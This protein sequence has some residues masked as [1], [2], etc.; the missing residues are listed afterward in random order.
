MTLEE[1]Q[2]AAGP[3]AFIP[4]HPGAPFEALEVVMARAVKP[5]RKYLLWID[6]VWGDWR[7][8]LVMEKGKTAEPLTLRFWDFSALPALGSG[9]GKLLWQCPAGASASF[10]GSNL[11]LAGAG[12]AV[13]TQV[14]GNDILLPVKSDTV[15]LA[16]DEGVRCGV[17]SGSLAPAESAKWIALLTPHV[18]YRWDAGFPGVVKAARLLSDDAGD[19]SDVEA[20]FDFHCFD[21]SRTVSRIA[22]EAA[23]VGSSR[24]LSCISDTTGRNLHL[25]PS[26]GAA[27]YFETDRELT[28]HASLWGKF[29]IDTSGAVAP[30]A[31]GTQT[32]E[33]MPGSAGTEFFQLFEAG[34]D[35][36]QFF[37]GQSAFVEFG[38]E[39][40]PPK[41][42]DRSTTAWIAPCRTGEEAAWARSGFGYVAQPQEHPLYGRRNIA[43]LGVGLLDTPSTVL[44]DPAPRR[45]DVCM[46][47]FPFRGVRDGELDQTRQLDINALAHERATIAARSVAAQGPALGALEDAPP[48]TSTITTP[49]GLLID[50]DAQNQ[51]K[52][53]TLG[54]AAGDWS[55]SIPRPD[56]VKRWALQESLS[57][58]DPF[59]VIG[60]Q[61]PP[62]LPGPAEPVVGTIELSLAIAGWPLKLKVADAVAAPLPLPPAPSPAPTPGQRPA[63][64]P[65]LP[66]AGS[67]PVLVIK[68]AKGSLKDMLQ[69]AGLW[70]MA[71]VFN[72]DPAR[73]STEAVA[74]LY[75]LEQLKNGLSPL[76]VPADQ[77]PISQELVPYYK[78]L[79]AKVTDPE[80]TGALIFNG[81]T[82]LNGIPGHVAVLTQGEN[83]PDSFNVPVLGVDI[84]RVVPSGSQMKLER[85][86]A[87]G[88]IHYHS[89]QPLDPKAA[90]F[91]FKVRGVNAVFDNTEL[92]T[93]LATMQLRVGEYFGEK[94]KLEQ[95]GGKSRILDI[96]GRYEA[97]TAGDGQYIFR[98]LGS[99]S[100]DFGG[101]GL[102]SSLTVTRIDVTS[103]RLGDGTIESRFAMWGELAFGNRFSG[104]TGI[105]KI[106]FENAALILRGAQFGADAGDVRVAFDRT[107]ASDPHGL[108]ANFPFQLSG[109]RWA[110]K[111]QTLEGAGF[112]G[113]Q[114]P[115]ISGFEGSNFEFGLELDLNLGSMGKLFEAAQFLKARVLLG[116]HLWEENGTIRRE[117]SIGFRFVGGN[118]PLDI[119]ING[120]LRLTAEQVLLKTYDH[121]PGIGLGLYKPQLDV[122][123][124]KVPSNPRDTL[125]AFLPS[126]KDSIAW[127][128]ARPS[129]TVGPLELDYFAM[130]QRV[131]LVPSGA[132]GPGAT[133]QSVIDASCKQMNPSV[134]SSGVATFPDIGSLY[135]PEAGWG[136]V[137]RG[138]VSS[139]A[140]RFVFMD[141]IDR[142]GLGVDIP[143]IAK[144][145]VLYRKLSDGLG[146]F[147]AEIEPLYRSFEFGTANVTLPIV[148]F[149]ALTN[150]GWS[151]NIGY[152]GNDFS[153]GT[154]VQVLPFI[155]SGGV[156]FGRLD[157]R[158]SYVLNSPD[159]TRSELIRQLDLNPVI[160]MSFAARV[161]IGKEFREGVFTAGITLSVYGIF[162]GAIGTPQDPRFASTGRPRRYLKIYGAAGILL[163]IF[164]SVNFAIVSAAVS[165]RVWVETGIRFETWAPVL[166][167]A[168]A[169]VSVYVHFVI[170]RFSVFG[171]TIEIAIDFS[172]STRVR[173]TQ[174]IADSFDGSLP[175]VYKPY[176]GLSMEPM[177]LHPFAEHAALAP[178]R[179]DPHTVAATPA[180]QSCAVTLEPMIADSKPVLLPLLVASGS[181]SP[182]IATFGIHLF[183][184]ALRLSLGLAPADPLPARVQVDALRALAL[185]L[186]PPKGVPLSRWGEVPLDFAQLQKFMESHLR[187]E[188][189][190][191]ADLRAEQGRQHVTGTL[192]PW[193]ADLAILGSVDTAGGKPIRDFRG[194]DATLVDDS[195]EKSLYDDLA[196]S[197]PLYR[198]VEAPQQVKMAL[199]DAGQVAF[200][201]GSK[202]SLDVVA[203]D[204]AA[205]L[206]QGVAH[207]AIQA[208]EVLLGKDPHASDIA[209]Q[210]LL[211][212]L[213]LPDHDGTPAVQV[214]QHASSFLHHGLRVP[215]SDRSAGSL[216]LS[217][218]LRTELGLEGLAAQGRNW[219]LTVRPVTGFAGPWIDGICDI[220]AF[221]AGAALSRM[222]ELQAKLAT[223]KIRI[224]AR[225][226]D[227]L[228]ATTRPRRFT[229]S[230]GVASAPPSS[231]VST[232][233][234]LRLPR[235]LL[236]LLQRNGPQVVATSTD[237]PQD[238]D[239]PAPCPLRSFARIELRLGLPRV[240]GGNSYPVLNADQR[241]REL[242]K[243][244]TN[245]VALRRAWLAFGD[246]KLQPTV[247]L[248]LLADDDVLMFV[249]NFSREPAPEIQMLQ[250]LSEPEIPASSTL[251]TPDKLAQVLWMAS[252][253]NAPGFELAFRKGN[254]IAHLFK[255]ATV[256][257]ADILFELSTADILHPV[258]D[259]LMADEADAKR[260]VIIETTKIRELV[261]GT[262]DGQ[263]AIEL[264][265]KNPFFNA[266][267]TP[268]V[269]DFA[270]FRAR[271]ELADYEMKDGSL[272]RAKVVPVRVWLDDAEREAARAAEPEWWT[273]RLLVPLSRIADASP[274][275]SIGKDLKDLIVPGLRDGA[276]HYLDEP[277]IDFAWVG[278]NTKVLYRDAIP[279]LE[280]IPG[281]TAAWQLE[282]AAAGPRAVV[283]LLWSSSQ[284][285]SDLKKNDARRIALRGQFER[286]AAMF[287]A[288]GFTAHAD[289]GF[290]GH[291]VA[292]EDIRQRLLDWLRAVVKELEDASD[293]D[294]TC[295]PIVIV[296]PAA[297]LPATTQTPYAM[298]VGITLE[299]EEALCDKRTGN[300]DIWFARSCVAPGGL[301]SAANWLDW[302][303]QVRT[304]FDET[305]T[306]VRLQR[307]RA[308]SVGDRAE[309]PVPYLMRSS[310]LV[311]GSAHATQAVF[312]AP[313]PLAKTL[314]SGSAEVPLPNGQTEQY[315]VTDMDM[316][317]VASR[318]ADAIEALLDPRAAA[319]LCLDAPAQYARLAHAKRSIAELMA[320]RLASVLDKGAAASNEVREKFR[321]AARADVRAA[322]AP[323]AAVEVQL[324]PATISDPKTFLWGHID[325]GDPKVPSADGLAFS[326]VR[327]PLGQAGIEG[328][329]D[330]VARWAAPGTEPV[331]ALRGRMSMQ[332]I[333]VEVQGGKEIDGY[334]PSDWYEVLWTDEMKGADFI[335]SSPTGQEWTIPLPLR[336][337]PPTPSI[338]R[339]GFDSTGTASAR[340]LQDYVRRARAW[341]YVISLMVPATS[342]DTTEVAVR[343]DDSPSLR[344]LA[345]DLLFSALAAFAR[346]E[347]LVAQVTAQLIAGTSPDPKDVQL[348]VSL[349]ESIATALAS[350]PVVPAL[351]DFASQTRTAVLAKS[352]N[353]AET[354]LRWTVT[355]PE[356]QTS[357]SA[358][359]LLLT[360]ENASEASEPIAADALDPQAGI[361]TY[362]HRPVVDTTLAGV[363]GLSPRQVRMSALDVMVHGNAMPRVMSR[364]NAELAGAGVM[365]SP[366]FI[367]ETPAVQTPDPLIPHLVHTEQYDM[368]GGAAA[369]PLAAWLSE[370]RTALAS[371]AN[372]DTFTLDI[373]ARFQLPLASSGGTTINYYAPLPSLKEVKPADGDW[374]LVLAGYLQPALE[375]VEPA[376]RQHG[377]LQLKVKIFH[378]A[379]HGAKRPALSLDELELPLAKVTLKP[380]LPT[381][382]PAGA[383]A[384]T[385][386]WTPWPI[387]SF[388]FERMRGLTGDAEQLELARLAWAHFAI[389]A[390]EPMIATSTPPRVADLETRSDAVEWALCNKAAANAVSSAAGVT[391]AL[392]ECAPSPQEA[393][394]PM[395]AFAGEV[396]KIAGPLRRRG[397]ERHLFLWG[398]PS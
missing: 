226:E 92:R 394:W 123:G 203:E 367:F 373:T 331:A 314:R 236:A 250:A 244:M 116:W 385:F 310:M 44:F 95:P 346:H 194:A 40:K 252:T 64:P 77:K 28:A 35:G 388:V 187:L 3:F 237:D 73:V 359:L 340:D 231:T 246:A 247:P 224:E 173:I 58:P 273:H 322:F 299:R 206:V 16:L 336:L 212:A 264:R 146:I 148:N 297:S 333:Y 235:P 343:F 15:R 392:L 300:S 362:R 384:L 279:Q 74:A 308:S 360:P 220:D 147:S 93:F 350:T 80:W 335:I 210:N 261:S 241:I 6:P 161:G 282:R 358:S 353:A 249:S 309:V 60:A 48:P 366:A 55:L 204:W 85:T 151:I 170:A 230:D 216:P 155:G 316:N 245:G 21:A 202:N 36:L 339:H 345:T 185:R 183:T 377:T 56:G 115:G 169:G 128:W 361:A 118:G 342:H 368:S 215:P 108:L 328:S 296:I 100:F 132:F 319:P 251:A 332:P 145:D 130:G 321:D 260:I 150:G 10:A 94:S 222:N 172:F 356:F 96:I 79:Y 351:I 20:Q 84:N 195:W 348:S 17:V 313:T 184:W 209:L 37:P 272:A 281:V 233:R 295:A 54:E 276:G 117:F 255:D 369:K 221:D 47:F 122:M 227:D 376:S 301:Q 375:R 262:P 39:T 120:V 307:S 395:S 284:L 196:Q 286:W 382:K 265:R 192:L 138:K 70:T 326:P 126:G 200:Q 302:A 266:P 344:P 125:L 135:S 258:A 34:H 280:E 46:P 160:E 144:V 274:Y 158:S 294:C 293:K 18:R 14:D 243:A 149:D 271:Y 29:R 162:E 174:Q 378:A 263:V 275:A 99:R 352:T 86:S 24:L 218:M 65:E 177:R 133:L 380:V 89:P 41:I 43:A 201:A 242:V 59:V 82:P 175:D 232:M 164:G 129:T 110:P 67:A 391:Y 134:D 287:S 381:P 152:H 306:L 268:D 5:G 365:I 9:D 253:V 324:S 168:E 205:A 166:V 325:V 387:A 254:P 211:D 390:A 103:L 338:L 292:R 188:L 171:H 112:T 189:C 223:D 298:E 32:C 182:G 30:A 4:A 364:R 257:S 131:A 389:S 102:L 167:H 113:L 153:R 181:D 238:S 8:V 178:L 101:D 57:R 127:A 239:P 23:A 157:W 228:E 214:A 63:S 137:A 78:A 61:R 240:A 374:S 81:N 1:A 98:A 91:A 372:G 26:G 139:F 68:L 317:A 386:G 159:S 393:G 278:N 191:V 53:I 291:V 197:R 19:H 357:V 341:T 106:S 270:A 69:D 25:K 193:F 199:F 396:E 49:H 269:Q 140:F 207:R 371:G 190:K 75:N 119:G 111:L 33:V 76:P 22:L 176:A 114:L 2:A 303:R 42:T 97:R 234:L 289:L 7:D 66:Y 87:F 186:E 27:I 72:N 370:L 163:E 143:A 256:A 154:T 330:F 363:A 288:I 165:I 51:W 124:Y 355:P 259:G 156:R 71:H 52:R 283:K 305:F 38:D 105:R 142:Y 379:S 50:V 337:I 13:L 354:T 315:V 320:G 383:A 334:R 267:G 109:L 121:P 329:F 225:Y 277:S 11:V 90:G 327:I 62:G 31:A 219:Q 229:A 312:H 347:R 45:V 304:V 198:D 217:Q 398:I 180:R 311:P 12:M 318:A 285:F 107:S 208:G 213:A 179:W 290:G 104:I 397:D 88:A 248:R 349:F 83:M 136:V 141:G 323:V